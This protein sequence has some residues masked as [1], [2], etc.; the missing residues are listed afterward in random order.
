VPPNGIEARCEAITPTMLPLVQLSQEQID[1]IVRR[2]PGGAANVQDIYPLAP[3]QEGILFHHLLQQQGD[4]YLLVA[5]LSF[6]QRAQLDQF[7]RMLQ[8]V[9]TRHD[10]SAPSALRVPRA[11]S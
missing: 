3:L 11:R 5:M 7:V 9:I 2:V 10:K 8:R 6:D 1:Q 4:A